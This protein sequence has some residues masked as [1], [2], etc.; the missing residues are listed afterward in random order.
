MKASKNERKV[1]RSTMC[2][3]GKKRRGFRVTRKRRSEGSLP[4][5]K[6]SAL[7]GGKQAFGTLFIVNYVIV[8]FSP[9]GC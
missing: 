6:C 7:P 3:L 1:S 9:F 4:E 8:K 5:R 2:D